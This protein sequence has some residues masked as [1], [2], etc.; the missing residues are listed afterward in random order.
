MLGL[1]AAQSPDRQL[2]ESFVRTKD[3]AAFAALVDRH[4]GLVWGVCCRVARDTHSAE[5]AFQA[6]WLVLAR[7]A[8]SLRDGT[9]LPAWLHRVAYRLSLAARAKRMADLD[10]VPSAD[11][12]PEDEV[13]G[14]EACAIV[15]QEVNLLPEK[16][17]LPVVLCFL[18][19][20]THAEAAAELGWPIGT[21][22]GRLARAKELLHARLTRRGLAPLAWPLPVAGA[23]P[24][25][26]SS[27]AATAL[28]TAPLAGE[29][30]RRWL[31]GAAVLLLSCV[32]A[33]GAFLVLRAAR[34]PPPPPEVPSPTA[35]IPRTRIG[36]VEG[37]AFAVS[38]DGKQVAA[39]R[40]G[41]VRLFD[42]RT[43]AEVETLTAEGLRGSASLL[44]SPDGKWLVATAGMGLYVWDRASGQGRS[45]P[46]PAG[47]GRLHPTSRVGLI[48]FGPDGTLFSEL[49]ST[50]IYNTHAW[51]VRD[52]KRLQRFPGMFGALSP[53]GKTL[54][55]CDLDAGTTG[56]YDAKSGAKLY[57]LPGVVFPAFHPKD[58]VVAAVG[59]DAVVRLFDS[60]TGKEI[61]VLDPHLVVSGKSGVSPEVKK[62]CQELHIDVLLGDRLPLIFAQMSE[63]YGSNKAVE[64]IQRHDIL[65]GARAEWAFELRP[66]SFSPDGRLL[67][68]SFGQESH[69]WDVRDRK[70]R[71]TLTGS[72]RSFSPDGTRFATAYYLWD[73]ASGKQLSS[74]SIGGPLV[75]TRDG[76]TL[77]ARRDSIISRWDARTGRE[78]G[79]LGG[80][81]VVYSPDGTR[82]ATCSGK[83]VNVWDARTGQE[84]LTLADFDGYSVE[85]VA[86]SPEGDRI[87]GTG[88]IENPDHSD[89][90]TVCVWDAHTGRKI[91][92]W[93]IDGWIFGRV[94]L[95]PDGQ[96]LAGA[97]QAGLQ[98]WEARS[99]ELLLSLPAPVRPQDLFRDGRPL[100]REAAFSPDGSKIAA[101]VETNSGEDRDVKVW[102]VKVW[103]ARTGKDLL[104]LP[105]HTRIPP[106]LT[107]SRDGT[108]LAS[109]DSNN[110]TVRVWDVATRRNLLA[111][112]DADGPVAFSPDGRYLVTGSTVRDATSGKPVFDFPVYAEREAGPDRRRL[113]IESVA[114]SPD[115]KTLALECGGVV[116]LWDISAPPPPV[117]R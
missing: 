68:S 108:R 32:G 28:A 110:R 100:Y 33:A 23:I 15:D 88:R 38:P 64:S 4:G 7:K 76:E 71:A 69:L 57:D 89:S 72:P 74:H 43:G 25:V 102:D 30:H 16:Y 47:E 82:L 42:A 65:K 77:F 112:E 18:E 51:S 63:S 53:D 94:V 49:D 62:A 85:H 5:D 21:V 12:A 50:G 73:V 48:G 58:A 79:A 91:S 14:Q 78:Q 66:P 20:K 41:A 44:F 60:R 97:T 111:L 35:W 116:Y 17:R 106:W 46:L 99:G 31:I 115:G 10:D 70:V 84:K 6:T 26:A 75:F 37:T 1:D 92:S 22:A 83:A 98:L 105:S 54:A 117:A 40:D 90:K 96:R 29:T 87:V 80:Y 8:G 109:A 104:T 13:A 2:L 11:P 55:T 93:K 67:A 61:A 103:D 107:F 45:L 39:W 3:E 36:P 113:S 86:F 34:V 9:A 56:L 81:G 95:S 101:G 52:G 24:A 19:G 59:F 114:F 27:E